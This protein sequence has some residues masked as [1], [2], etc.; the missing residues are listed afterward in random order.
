M[1]DAS[2]LD[3]VGGVHAPAQSEQSTIPFA[4]D[5]SAPSRRT[6]LRTGVE[7]ITPVHDHVE[8]SFCRRNC[9]EHAPRSVFIEGNTVDTRPSKDLTMVGSVHAQAQSG[10]WVATTA[11][12]ST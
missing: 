5:L 8:G 7:A 10:H 9:G 1:A 4:E 3:E 2:G 12:A 11:I 6:G